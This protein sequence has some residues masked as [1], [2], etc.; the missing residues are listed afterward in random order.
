M[1]YHDTQNP[2]IGSLGGQLAGSEVTFVQN[3]AA[4]SYAQ[5]DVLYYDGTKLNRLPAGTSGFFLKT[6]GAGANPIWAASA[7]SGTVTTVSVNTASGFQGSV[8]N[9]TSSPAITVKNILTAI[10]GV[11]TLDDTYGVVKCTGT[12]YT[13]TLP[14]AV[15]V[16]G[17]QYTIKNSAS[18]NITIATTSAQTIDG[19]STAVIIPNTSLT[20]VSDN[21]NWILI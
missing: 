15:G 21:A 1:A 7:G 13:V 12:S 3:L 18:G 8:T 17:R 6:Q 4:L 10:S 16:Q 9:P 2:G 11:T 5:G 14:T 19:S 20:V